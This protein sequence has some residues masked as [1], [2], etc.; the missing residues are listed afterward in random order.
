MDI[1]HFRQF[2]EPGPHHAVLTIGNFDGVHLG[3]QA[4]IRQVVREAHQM[5]VASALLTFEPHPQSVLGDHPVPIITSMALRLRLFEALGLDS[6]YFIPFTRELAELSPE[7]FVQVYL[8]SYF[9]VQKLII[10]YDFHFGHNREGSAALLRALS[11]RYRFQFEVFPEFAL[12]GSKVSSTRIREALAACDFAAAGRLLGRPW[13]VLEP[14]AHGSG[15]GHELGFP[16]LNQVPGERLPLPFGVYAT[17]ALIEGRPYAGVSNYGVKPTVGVHPPT[18]ETHLFDFA[19]AL[20]GE[21][22]EVVPLRRLREERTFPS[23]DAL[24]HQIAADREQARAFHA[25]QEA[26]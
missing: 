8:L 26:R 20:Y 2:D 16:T 3:H 10:G 9:Q 6:A 15:R 7:A 13:S 14:V 18:L 22:V 12:D 24:R 5:G 17:R 11:Q 4:L 1:F 23:L 19:E 21:L 25:T